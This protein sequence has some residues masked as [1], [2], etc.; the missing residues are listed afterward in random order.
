MKRL[1]LVLCL[2]LTLV[3][4]SNGGNAKRVGVIQFVKH[5]ALDLATQGFVEVVDG[6]FGEGTCDVQIGGGDASTCNVTISSFVSE[7]YD[8]I[9]C[10]ATPALQVASKATKSIPILGTS[11]TEY[12]I[13]LGIENFNGKTGI[14]I[15]GTSDLAP[16]DKQAEIFKELLPNIKT[17]ALLY[18]TNEA[19]SNY[20]IEK[21][22]K[23]LNDLGYVTKRY[24]FSEMQYLASTV[25]AACLEN[26]AMYIPTDNACADD[27][28]IIAKQANNTNTPI[29]CG[30]KSILENCGGL[31]TLSIDYFEL[32]KITGEM[33]V[34]VLKG[35]EKIEN[36]KIEDYPNPVKMISKSKAEKFGIDIPEG[37]EIID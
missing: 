27:E 24:G 1:L 35:E 36:M 22:E 9:L 21:V 29:V 5:D 30:E 23:Y 32:G 33:A 13:A 18:C 10:N 11:V 37:Y 26:D 28:G 8:L 12:G 17:I 6:E 15:S 2:L 31:A 3:G 16:L 20:Q 19:N 4:C 14:N 25:E 7:N 34:R